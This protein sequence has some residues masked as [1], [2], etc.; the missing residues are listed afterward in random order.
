[1]WCRPG[2]RERNQSECPRCG[3]KT[4]VEVRVQVNWCPHCRI[5]LIQEVN[6]KEPCALCGGTASYIAQVLR[7]VFSQ[8]R[9]LVVLVL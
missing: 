9:L 3:N 1:M 2:N 4:E 6:S 8:E 7:P 5:P